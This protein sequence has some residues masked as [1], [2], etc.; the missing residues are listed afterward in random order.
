MKIIDFIALFIFYFFIL[1]KKWKKKGRDTLLVNTLMY[2]YLSFVFYFTLMP[3]ITSLPFLLSH[4]YTRMNLTPFS[5]LINNRGAYIKELVLNIIMMVPFGFLFPL[6]GKKK[7]GFF[8]TMLSAFLLSLGIEVLQPF[9]N[10]MR[11]SDIT[12]LITN[13]MGGSIGYIL[14]ILCRPLTTFVLNYIKKSDSVNKN[15]ISSV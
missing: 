3:V 2:I 14:F 4:T 15:L 6:V 8:K 1:L 13:T 12:D 11:T 7:N 10:G 5:D 9:I